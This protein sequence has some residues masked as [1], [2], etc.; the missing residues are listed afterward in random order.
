MEDDETLASRR[1][2][3]IVGGRWTLERLLGTGGV[4]AVY[5][6]TDGLGQ[7]AAVKILHE[8]LGRRKDVRERFLREGTLANRVDHEGALRVLEQGVTEEGTGYLV[9]ELLEGETLTQLIRRDGPLG[10]REL[11]G[12]LDQVLDIL[13]A[14]HAVGVI[15][16]DLKPDNL[17]ITSNGKLKVLDYGLARS[18]SDIQGCFKTKTGLA[19]GTLPYMAPEQARGRR[20]EVDGRVDLFALGATAFRV[21][22][23]RRVHDAE[24]EAELLLKMAFEPA[25]KLGSVAPSVPVAAQRVV[26]LALAF[27]K[28]ARYPDAITMQRD[29]RDVLAGRQPTHACARLQALDSATRVEPAIAVTPHGESSPRSAPTAPLSARLAKTEPLPVSASFTGPAGPAAAPPA[30]APP[31]PVDPTQASPARR[32]RRLVPW[33]ALIAAV[34][35]AGVGL[36]VLMIQPADTTA[37]DS[38]PAPQLAATI[39][40]PVRAQPGFDAPT[41]PTAA[42]TASAHQKL[43]ADS[44]PE[45]P[46]RSPRAKPRAASVEPEPQ[47]HAST[48]ATA[49]PA[50]NRAGPTEARATRVTRPLRLTRPSD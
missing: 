43:V 29:V 50:P 6:A 3:H 48:G 32:G 10:V 45:P 30:W 15:H 37:D 33:L 34:L 7:R 38:V 20:A 36:T 49:P 24:T 8:D 46:Q 39:P 47:P 23:R 18:L 14:A 22:A 11:F 5:A 27:A 16:R 13:I 4:G 25:P 35:A 41:P 26:D 19:L 17:F 1:L 40:Q 12:I 31:P 42:A 2:G 9:M 21:L 44:E 28:E